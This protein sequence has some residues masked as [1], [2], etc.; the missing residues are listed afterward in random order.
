MFGWCLEKV[1]FVVD[2]CKSVFIVQYGNTQ[3]FLLLNMQF[4]LLFY[5]SLLSF[6]KR[7]EMFCS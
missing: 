7:E 2:D 4:L 3:W 5:I 1:E 6:V